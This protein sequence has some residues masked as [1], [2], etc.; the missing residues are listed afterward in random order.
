MH[1]FR[2]STIYLCISTRQLS[3]LERLAT[4]LDTPVDTGSILLIV[5]SFSEKIR[6]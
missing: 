6:I 1:Q 5:V 3:Y 4:A 2:V